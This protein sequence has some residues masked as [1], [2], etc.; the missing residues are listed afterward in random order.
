VSYC[1]NEVTCRRTLL[2]EYFGETFTSNKCNKTCDN[3]IREGQVDSVDF[4]GMAQRAL[5]CVEEYLSLNLPPPTMAT[6]CKIFM[7]QGSKAKGMERYDA[8]R[9]R[10]DD[11]KRLNKDLCDRLFQ[12]MVMQDYLVEEPKVGRTRIYRIR[13]SNVC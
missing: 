12:V 10:C 13:E 8:I 1:L 11:T 7:G 4:T 9:T 2:L 3:C 5:M 6:M